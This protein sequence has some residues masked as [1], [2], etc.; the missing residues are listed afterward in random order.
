M[1]S[2]YKKTTKTKNNMYG[3][4][5]ITDITIINNPILLC[6][7]N[8]LQN[9]KSVFGIMRDG[10][11]AARIHTTQE[12]AAN[13]NIDKVPIEF[14]GIKYKE[15]DKSVEEELLD[16]LI[17]PY[18]TKNGEDINS[19]LKQARNINVFTFDTGTT[20]YLKVE[21]LLQNKLKQLGFK[22]GEIETIIRQIALI[23]LGSKE[24]LDKTLSTT[25]SFV[26]TNDKYCSTKEFN[27]YK[28]V[29]EEKNI[30]SM[31]FYWGEKNT[32]LYP[33]ISIGEHY[34]KKYL[35][36][37]SPAKSAISST[38]SSNLNNSIIN[39]YN[40]PTKM[41]R[42][43]NIDQLYYYG[44]NV[45]SNEDKIRLLDQ[46]LDYQYAIKFTEEESELR[47]N[48]DSSYKKIISQEQLIESYKKEITNK[49]KRLE[50]LLKELKNHCN[51]NKYYE[52]LSA[53]NLWNNKKDNK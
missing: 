29:M 35:E 11:H 13:Y 9:N 17:Y 47:T 37:Y 42:D 46:Y 5:E 33:F 53:A 24:K 44:S 7:S 27:S 28:K 36:S 16:K 34:P 51:K 32:I 40:N 21:K 8:N 43:A 45:Y 12:K 52:I 18:L 6:I 41:A 1:L 15:E 3:F 31:Y 25:I 48:L 4:T 14:L 20:I 19:L 26:D 38:V 22:K 10:A 50:L 30:N 23:S 39:N 2:I 49:D